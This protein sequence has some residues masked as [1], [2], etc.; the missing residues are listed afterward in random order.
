MYLQKQKRALHETR[1]CCKVLGLGTV[2]GVTLAQSFVLRKK[3]ADQKITRIRMVT[4]EQ[5]LDD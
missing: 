4:P 1:K 2:E 3:A 5:S